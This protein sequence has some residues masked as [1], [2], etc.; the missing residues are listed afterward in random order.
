VFAADAVIDYCDEHG[1]IG[2]L[3]TIKRFMAAFGGRPHS[4]QFMVAT[5][6]VRLDGDTATGR[7]IS[8]H[9]VVHER[10]DGSSHVY[11]CGHWYVDRFVRTASGWRIAARATERGYYYHL[12]PELAFRAAQHDDDCPCTAAWDR[13]SATSG[14]PPASG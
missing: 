10:P 8:H 12:P 1:P 4:S 13:V 7:S 9:P 14:S 6:T 2:D 11:F 5:T 3:A